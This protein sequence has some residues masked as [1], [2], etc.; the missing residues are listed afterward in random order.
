MAQKPLSIL[1]SG[2]GIAG[3]SLALMIAHQPSFNPKPIVTLVERSP[4]PRVTGQAIDIR[5]PAV[6]VIRQLDLEQKIKDR[7]TTEVGMSWVNGKGEKI[8]RFDA[9]GN[10]EKQSTTSEYEILRAELTDLLL[11]EVEAA[12]EAGLLNIRIVY[13]ESIES[14]KESEGGVEV[15]FAGGELET[16]KFDVVVAADGYASKTRSMIFE[17]QTVQDYLKPAGWYVA[18]F[19][20]P[21][22]ES[23]DN[24]WHIYN[25]PR[26][27]TAFLR[28]HRNKANVGAYLGIANSKK[29][30]LPEVDEV[31]SKDV[32]TQ[33]SFLRQLFKGAGWQTDRLLDGMDH[34]DDFYMQAVAQV[35]APQWTKGRCALLGDTAFATMGMGTSMAMIGAYIIAGELAKVDSTKPGEVS[36]A[37]KRYE[38]IL[39]PF[40]KKHQKELP[41]FPQM[42]SPQSNIGIGA[43]HTIVRLASWIRIDKYFGG[44]D[45]AEDEWKLPDYGYGR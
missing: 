5:G 14:V 34:S 16:Q 4:Q 32:A 33:K 7:H 39:R 22:V 11:Q 24:Y 1:I 26:G 44:N 8:A 36:A 25:A 3:A 43:L 9:S 45:M 17:N 15:Q 28:P 35:R 23:D 41:G 27:L 10:S 2:A 29:E 12:R 37:L 42:M 38:E 31:L 19:T 21:R 40:V 20:I 6:K 30:R 13:G 18:F